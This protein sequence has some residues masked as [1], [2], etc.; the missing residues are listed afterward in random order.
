MQSCFVVGMTELSVA[1]VLR[2]APS[3]KPGGVTVAPAAGSGPRPDKVVPIPSTVQ[4]ASSANAPSRSPP[5]TAIGVASVNVFK[6]AVSVSTGDSPTTVK[7][8]G[9]LGGLGAG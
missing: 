2:R 4:S 1:D 9:G 8:L 5:C 3:K 7:E 6:P